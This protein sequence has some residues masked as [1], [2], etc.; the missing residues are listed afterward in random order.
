MPPESSTIGDARKPRISL[1][2][3]V[4]QRDATD[5]S[6]ELD[7]FVDSRRKNFREVRLALEKRHRSKTNARLEANKKI[8]RESA[9]TVPQTGDLVLVRESSN[10]V[11]RDGSGGKLEHER[12]TGPWKITKVLNAGLTIEVVMEGRSTQICHVSPKCIKPFHARPPDLRHPLADEFAQL[13]W[14]A[15]IGPTTPSLVA[16]PLYTLYDR[17]N[18]TSATGVPKW[19]YRGKYHKSKPSQWMA[20][21]E[22]SS[23]FNRLQLNVFHARWNLYNPHL[24]QV[25]QNSSRKRSQPRPRED[26][27]RLFPIGTTAVKKSGS[28]TLPGQVY[29]YRVPYRRVLYE[30]DDWEELSRQEVRR[31]ARSTP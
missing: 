11:E 22:I 29:D 31:T 8:I 2:T 24:P 9:G 7:N 19:E 3:L 15:D 30:D 4:P 1:D 27:L 6:G 17:R 12:G 28:K 20:E 18:V 26:A 13:A 10:N 25:Q 14:S 5:R 21:T 23:S 16:K